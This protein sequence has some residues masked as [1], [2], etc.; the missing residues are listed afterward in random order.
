MVGST[1]G[2]DGGDLVGGAVARGAIVVLVG[3]FVM[4]IVGKTTGAM[5]L[6]LF[7][8]GWGVFF[9][10]KILLLLGWGVVFLVNTLGFVGAKVN[11]A[12]G[13]ALVLFKV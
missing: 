10:V 4:G 6:L 13:D 11:T 3:S 1:V 2:E 8:L 9:L 5:L 7:L 12:N